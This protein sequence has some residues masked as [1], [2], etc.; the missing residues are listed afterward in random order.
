MTERQ[1]RADFTPGRQRLP[2]AYAKADRR[3]RQ[4]VRNV[5]S[6]F[7]HANLAEQ[8]ARLKRGR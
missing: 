6:A 8:K 5:V 3:S 7:S 4:I 1:R 2:I